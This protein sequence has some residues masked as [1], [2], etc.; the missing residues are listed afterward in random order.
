MAQLHFDTSALIRRYDSH[1][2]GASL[3]REACDP[4]N[5]NT[6]TIC[7]LT[8]VEIASSVGRRLREGVYPPEIITKLWRTFQYDWH[9]HYV[10][11]ALTPSLLRRAEALVLRQH[12]RA[13]D[14]I[15]LAS[16]IMSAMES[17]VEFWTADARQAHAAMAEGMTTRI[18]S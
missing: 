2:P 14:A 8:S 18:V 15:H 11:V 13:A 16:A 6:V 12:L 5:G 1:E 17:N 9:T 10:V 4:D 7:E 3:V